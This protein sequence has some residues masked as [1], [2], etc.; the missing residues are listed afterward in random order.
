M[1]FNGLFQLSST[2]FFRNVLFY[3]I[4]DKYRVSRQKAVIQKR[5]T[6]IPIL[7]LPMLQIK[8]SCSYQISGRVAMLQIKKSHS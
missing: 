7:V 2:N 6:L 4:D 8:R 5:H 1:H 3:D